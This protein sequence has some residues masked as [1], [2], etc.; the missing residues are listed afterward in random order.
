MSD[1]TELIVAM[2]SIIGILAV[3]IKLLLNSWFKKSHELEDEKKKNM[4]QTQNRLDD[5]LKVLRSIITTLQ[6][7][8]RTLISK[9]DKAEGRIEALELTLSQ[10]IK[11]WEDLHNS[12]SDKLRNLIKTEIVEL[13]KNAA[14]IRAKK[15][16]P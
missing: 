4:A 6:E 7:T 2:G 9:L 12:H 10:T 15:N 13:T 5:E 14:L 8:V 11:M 1:A 3:A 16:G